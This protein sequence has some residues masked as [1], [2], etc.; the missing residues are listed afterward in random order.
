MPWLAVKLNSQTH[1]KHPA[2]QIT[3]AKVN[4]L[5][6]YI[7]LIYYRARVKAKI[8]FIQLCDDIFHNY[9][10]ITP[11]PFPLKHGILEPQAYIRQRTVAPLYHRRRAKKTIEKANTYMY[12]LQSLES[13]QIVCMK[14]RLRLP[15]ILYWFFKTCRSKILNRDLSPFFI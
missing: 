12:Q 10:I 2:E 14:F 6:Q 4:A 8:T 13:K 3:S 5:R 11:P 15:C 1:T 9:I 7:I